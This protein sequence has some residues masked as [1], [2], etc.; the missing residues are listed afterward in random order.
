MTEKMHYHHLVSDME[1]KVSYGTLGLMN[2]IATYTEDMPHLKKN[3]FLINGMTIVRNCLSEKRGYT[4]KQLLDQISYDFEQLKQ[5]IE[6]YARHPMYSI[7]YFHPDINKLIPEEHRRTTTP[8]REN[9]ERIG[10]VILSHEKYQRDRLTSIDTTTHVKYYGVHLSSIFAYKFLA[11]TIHS[12]VSNDIPKIWLMSHHPIDYFLLDSFTTGEIV[13][14]HT[15]KILPKSQI[16]TKVFGTQDIPFNR[17]TYKLFGDKDLLK[18]VIRNRPKALE[19]LKGINLH[20]KTER[21]IGLLAMSKLGIDK[22]SISW[23][24]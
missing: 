1:E 3:F 24:L 22:K 23:H 2:A 4:D 12:L 13:L 7:V 18:P 14:S 20:H 19:M 21:E 5:V 6:I 17:M 16:P 10:R 11:K 8:I 15:G 9:V